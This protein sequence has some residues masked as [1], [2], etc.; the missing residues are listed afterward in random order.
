MHQ[1]RT[2][3]SAHKQVASATPPKIP[4]TQED[5]VSLNIDEEYTY[6]RHNEFM[7]EYGLEKVG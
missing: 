2:S 1:V 6:R 7:K 5:S 3:E 4:T